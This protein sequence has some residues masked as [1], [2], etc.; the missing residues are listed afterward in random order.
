[1]VLLVLLNSKSRGTVDQI[2]P[3]LMQR[4]LEK[5]HATYRSILGMLYKM[6]IH[7]D[8][9]AISESRKE[10]PQPSTRSRIKTKLDRGEGT[11]KNVFYVL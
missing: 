4:K 2:P 8:D 6:L 7:N 10:E 11:S 5:M 3:V 1:M 9:D